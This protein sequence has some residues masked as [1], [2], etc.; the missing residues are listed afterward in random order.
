MIDIMCEVSFEFKDYVAR[1]QLLTAEKV[2]RDRFTKSLAR[3][4]GRYP[5]VR[6]GAAFPSVTPKSSRQKASVA[7]SQA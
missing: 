4:K 2:K 7:Q 5:C 1:V 3:I 6:K